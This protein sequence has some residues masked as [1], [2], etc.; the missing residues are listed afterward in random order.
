M[1]NFY[2]DNADLK[3][4]V[5]QEVDWEP[6]VRL[7]EYGYGAE[8]GFTNVEEAVEFFTSVLD[9]VGDFAANEIAPHSAAIDREHP[10]L[11]DG[12][13][14]FPPVLQGIF[15][16]IKALEL[17]GMCVPRELG[18]MNSPFLLFVLSNELIARADVSVCAHNGFHGGSAMA[19]LLYSILEDTTGFDREQMCITSTRFGD[20]IAEI[21]AGEAWG[22]MDITEPGAGSD[23]AVMRTRGEQDEGGN[24]LVTGNKI[25]IT[26]GHA[27]YHFVIARTEEDSG[28]D[29]FSGLKGLSLFL[30]K[31][32]ETGDDGGLVKL[33]SFDGLEEKLGHH[34]SATVSIS[35][36]RSPAELIGERGDGF[37]LMLQLMNN[38]RVVVGFEALGICEA[39]LRLARDYAAERESMGKTIDRHEMIADYLDEMQ[40]DIQ[41]IRALAVRACFHEEMAQKLRLTLRFLPPEDEADRKKLE[42]DLA[43][44]QRVSR[45]YTPLLKYIAAEKAV[46]ISRRAI[47]IHGGYGY[48]S[49]YGAEKLLRD[50]MVLPIYEGTSQIQ[51]LM[52]MK[53][54]LLGILRDARRFVEKSTAARWRARSA[55]DPLA[56]RVARLQSQSYRALQFLMTRLAGTKFAEVR[57]QPVAEWKAAFASWDPKRD[58]AL[59]MLHAERLTRVLADVAIVEILADQAE[60]HPERA[61]V[62]ERY[63]ERAEPRCRFMVDEITTTGHRLLQTL[64]DGEE[65]SA[66]G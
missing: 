42:K 1:A 53:D 64:E 4:Y 45:R 60:R 65:E 39:A 11:D 27:K 20:A 17:H 62:L 24:W 16:Q 33:A 61:E 8:G 47:Q 38:A 55:R 5:E 2:D 48:S 66:A 28:A 26:S 34:G 36:D 14:L 56:R 51:A 6:L 50:A 25:F 13:V 3:Y 31:T 19:M 44:H 30:V 40:T 41:G 52:A 54:N 29:A 43:Y 49:E 21:V 63:L 9:M 57:R 7:T 23:M 15:D 46:E 58:F 22:S 10:Y 59:A 18:G 37:K 32:F 12:V 35:F